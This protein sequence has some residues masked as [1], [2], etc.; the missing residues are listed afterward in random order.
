MLQEKNR[1]GKPNFQSARVN[2]RFFFA[3]LLIV[4]F[5]CKKRDGFLKE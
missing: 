1:K 4:I 5:G 2:D 3:W